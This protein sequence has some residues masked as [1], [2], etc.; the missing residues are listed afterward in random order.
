MSLGKVCLINWPY[1]NL[2]RVVSVETSSFHFTMSRRD[3]IQKVD[4]NAA[5]WQVKCM[6]LQNRYLEKRIEV[7]EIKM[8]LH[9]A[10]LEG[11]VLVQDHTDNKATQYRLQRKYSDQTVAVPI[12]L[13]RYS[14]VQVVYL[15]MRVN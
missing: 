8:L 1:S 12:Q 14:T 7:G 5:E 13:T 10:E 11:M 6:D 4:N 2:A 15:E 9:V 3:K